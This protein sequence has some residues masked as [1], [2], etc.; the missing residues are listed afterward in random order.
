MFGLHIQESAAFDQG[1]VEAL[2]IRS[3]AKSAASKM[4][5]IE[6]SM[7][8]VM[9]DLFLKIYQDLFQH[10]D[11][12]DDDDAGGDDD[13]DD[14]AAAA[15][16][17]GGGGDGDDGVDFMFMFMFFIFRTV[18]NFVGTNPSLYITHALTSRV[19]KFQDQSLLR[20]FG[21]GCRQLL[22]ETSRLLDIDA[23]CVIGTSWI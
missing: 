8:H 13:D 4:D 11:D 7:L 3:C 2:T 5:R 14:A 1:A 15:G 21:S 12:D 22:H 9:T 19:V 20:L 10:D 16:G 17:G 18:R 23:A 6:K